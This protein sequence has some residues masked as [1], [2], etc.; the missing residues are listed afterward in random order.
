MIAA[1]IAS[2]AK[3]SHTGRKRAATAALATS[4]LTGAVTAVLGGARVKS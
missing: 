4:V 3:A 1:T 2:A